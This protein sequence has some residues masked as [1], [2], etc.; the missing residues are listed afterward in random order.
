MPAVRLTL[1]SKPGCHLCDD[2]RD[3]VT[4]VI[5]ETGVEASVEEL[6]IL[7]DEA[8]NS[9]YWDE[10]PVVLIDDRVHTIWRVDPAR[11]ATALREAAG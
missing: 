8:L 9:R 7:E 3:A 6:N 10:I 4:A 11:L 1:L 5:A 2:A